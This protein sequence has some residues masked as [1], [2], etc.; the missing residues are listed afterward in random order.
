MIQDNHFSQTVLLQGG[1]DLENNHK[2]KLPGTLID[3]RNFSA[4]NG[5]GYELVGGYERF[6]GQ[7]RPSIAADSAA[8]RALIQPV[9]GEGAV[10]GV[11]QYKGDVYAF[12]NAVGGASAKM[13]KSSPTG[14]AEVPTGVTLA[15]DGRYEFV[16]YNFYGATAL[17][18]MFGVDGKNKAFMWDGVTFTQLNVPGEVS[19]PEHLAAHA[20]HLFLSYP[21]GQWVHSGIGVPTNFDAATGGAG[22]GGS[23]DDIVALKPTVGGALAFMMR[24]RVSMLYGASQLDWQAN[25]MRPQEDQQGAIAGSIQSVGGDLLYLDDIGLTTLQAS[26]S[27]GNFE[28]ST[29]DYLIHTYLIQ[30]KDRVLTSI[31]SHQKSQYRLFLSHT[32]GTEVITLTFGQGGQMKGFG[33]FVYPFRVSCVTGSENMAGIQ[34]LYAGGED[35]YIYQLDIGNS[36]DGAD[37]EAWIK[38]SYLNVGDDRVRK[39]FKK[40]VLNV[41]TG[42]QVPLKIRGSFDYGHTGRPSTN[43]TDLDTGVSAAYWNEVNWNEF[44]WSGPEVGEVLA[45]VQGIGRNLSLYVYYKGQSTNHLVLHDAT[46]TFALRGKVRGI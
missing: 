4:A 14:W 45:D 46:L 38:T 3:C 39:R 18:A 17:Q 19:L 13:F 5:G 41:E 25:D 29:L 35:G 36:F 9:P 28:S 6:D 31:I 37:I 32:S 34:E 7:P 8:A 40:A 42:A 1:L 30:R 16:N 23:G 20:N 10:L 26:Q 11:W 44:Q 33:R 22:A 12:R 21:K 2:A 43:V 24:N 15:P 27:F